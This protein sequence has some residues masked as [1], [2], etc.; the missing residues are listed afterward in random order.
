MAE[1]PKPKKPQRKNSKKITLSKNKSW[2]D[3]V[4]GVDKKEVPIHI[5]Q[6]IE[7]KLIDGTNISID[8]KR[9]IEDGMDPIAIEELLDLKFNELDAYI[10]NVDFLIDIAKVVDTI[11]PETDQVLKGL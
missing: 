9:L 2:K 4:E 8:V 5:L 1:Q 6:E 11:Q 7:V 3:I 10:D